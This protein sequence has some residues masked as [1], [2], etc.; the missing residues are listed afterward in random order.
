MKLDRR[1]SEMVLALAQPSFRLL[2]QQKQH[3]GKIWLT[4]E[5][6]IRV[7]LHKIF[8]LLLLVTENENM[9]LKYLECIDFKQTASP[10]YN[11]ICNYSLK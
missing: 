2:K 11:V 5:V 1:I 7:S 3:R 8:I 6:A 4:A 9:L 10:K